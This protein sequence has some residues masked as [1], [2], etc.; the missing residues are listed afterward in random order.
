MHIFYIPMKAGDCTIWYDLFEKML[1]CGPHLSDE[2]I[3]DIFSEY[4]GRSK[5]EDIERAISMLEELIANG[6]DT[7][8]VRSILRSKRKIL[9]FFL[10]LRPTR[11][12][13]LTTKR[14]STILLNVGHCR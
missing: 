11:R 4:D 9:I 3:L 6:H 13:H 5:V 10:Y 7:I 14:I 12:H 1:S 2:N 8:C